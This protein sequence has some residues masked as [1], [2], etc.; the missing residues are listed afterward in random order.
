MQERA[1]LV[2]GFL[3]IRSALGEGSRVTL[4][5]PVDVAMTAADE[6][7]LASAAT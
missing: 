4:K 5:I 3:D 2:G 6:T 7:E 1:K